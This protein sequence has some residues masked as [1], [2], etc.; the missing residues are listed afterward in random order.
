M[1]WYNWYPKL[2]DG[3]VAVAVSDTPVGPFTIVN[4]HVQVTQADQRPGAGTLFVDDDGAGYYI[5]TAIA[6]NHAV[7]VERLT[8]DF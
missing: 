6:Q 5:Y 1:L 7:R 2:W 3:L 4:T 8:P